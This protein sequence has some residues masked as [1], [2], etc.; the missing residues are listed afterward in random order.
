MLKP[1]PC[2]SSFT[3]LRLFAALII[4]LA[5]LGLNPL[6]AQDWPAR[7][8]TMV[9]GTGAGGGSDIVGRALADRLGEVL[10]Q[11]VIVENIGTSVAAAARVARAQPNGYVFDFGFASTHA[12]HPSLYKK[13]VY[14]VINDFTPVGLVAEQPF[15]VVARKDFPADGL[16]AFAAYARLNQ[17]KLQYAS[18]TG[19]GSLNHLSC[20]LLNSALGVKITMVPYRDPGLAVQDM[21]AGRVDYQCMLPATM[22]PQILAGN[23]KGI[24][25]TGKNRLPQLPDLATA[26][27]QGL[28]GFDVESW[29]GFF[30]PKG[31]PDAIVRRLNAATKETMNTPAVQQRLQAISAT[32]VAPERRSPEYLRKFVAGEVERWAG[33]IKAA[34]LSLE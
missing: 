30:M 32:L 9:I 14:D 34:G 20:E 29:Y 13:P 22:I 12:L 31:V 3:Y 23:V 19:A 26:A 4:A 1:S 27:E 8:V 10:G 21:L 18:S 25:V 11:P 33:P 28:P 17:A 16:Q 7:P 15:V 24:A 6:Q 2:A 5:A